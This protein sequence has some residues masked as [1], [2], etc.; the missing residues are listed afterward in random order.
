MEDSKLDNRGLHK[1]IGSMN[2]LPSLDEKPGLLYLLHPLDNEL[3]N[4]GIETLIRAI[5]VEMANHHC[6]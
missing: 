3:D 4:H 6:H 2:T 1:P 5:L